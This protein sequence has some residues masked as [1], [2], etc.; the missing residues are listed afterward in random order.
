M[1][2]LQKKLKNERNI[3]CNVSF[4]TPTTYI[5]TQNFPVVRLP[6]RKTVTE[7]RAIAEA[8][9]FSNFSTNITGRKYLPPVER[10]DLVMPM[11][12]LYNNNELLPEDTI[13]DAFVFCNDFRQKLHN[14]FAGGYNR[15]ISAQS[16]SVV[17]SWTVDSLS[18]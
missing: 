14:A 8:E 16:G 6:G 18:I 12:G 1:F 2:L 9:L 7:W 15:P 4:S 13:C 10:E 5:E 3:G 17:Q 11:W